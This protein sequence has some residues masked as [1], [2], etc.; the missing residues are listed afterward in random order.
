MKFIS[1][2]TVVTDPQ[3]V[4]SAVSTPGEASSQ[5]GSVSVPRPSLQGKEGRRSSNGDRRSLGGSVKRSSKTTLH[6]IA[7]VGPEMRYISKRELLR[8]N[9]RLVIMEL[10]AF[11]VFTIAWW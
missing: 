6:F 2:A 3:Q 4:A 1:S 11:S 7:S 9:T 10:V 8:K 5:I